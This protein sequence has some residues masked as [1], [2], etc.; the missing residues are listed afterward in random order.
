VVCTLGG[1]TTTSNSINALFYEPPIP[2]E[3]VQTAPKVQPIQI[4]RILHEL[5]NQIRAENGLSRLD[6]SD[7]LADLARQHSEEMARLGYFDHSDKA[8]A[9]PTERAIQA[10]VASF[11][12]SDQY[13]MQGIGENLFLTHMFADY[14]VEQDKVLEVNWKTIDEI[15]E[16]AVDGWLNSPTHRANLLSNVYDEVAIGAAL[17]ENQTVFITQNFRFK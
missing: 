16:Q 11:K 4:E 6:W 10:G 3:A 14:T 8:G 17:G 12:L 9:D 5:V 7:D 2:V 15:A 1:C 13:V